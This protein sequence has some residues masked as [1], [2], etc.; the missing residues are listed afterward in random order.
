[1]E[2]RS[3]QWSAF[4]ENKDEQIRSNHGEVNKSIPR[5]S[6]QEAEALAERLS[7][8]E[9]FK[10]AQ[11]VLITWLQEGQCN[12]KNAMHFISLIQLCWN[13]YEKF[14]TEE[15]EY[16]EEAQKAEKNLVNQN[17][18]IQHQLSEIEEIFKVI[19]TEN[20]WSNFTEDQIKEIHMM[21]NDILDFKRVILKSSIVVEEGSSGMKNVN[22]EDVPIENI[23][24]NLQSHAGS[25]TYGLNTV[26]QRSGYLETKCKECVNEFLKLNSELKESRK[27]R[28]NNSISVED[29][30]TKNSDVASQCNLDQIHQNEMHIISLIS[31]FLY[32]N[33]DGVNINSVYSYLSK[34]IPV[35][36]V[37]EIENLMRR[38]P[39]IFEE[40]TPVDA[41]QETKWTCISISP[42]SLSQYLNK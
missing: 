2:K 32:R 27:R 21:R 14:K 1:M 36:C 6:E 37:A 41:T 3:D 16:L 26:N 20:I 11:Q 33:P 9:T 42:D 28:K 18:C 12:E 23:S 38:F 34:Y 19:D 15:K 17:W 4:L 40:S 10:E 25:L 39:K 5:Y 7:N 13:H 29:E 8:K 22:N 31:I 24:H 35:T 30:K